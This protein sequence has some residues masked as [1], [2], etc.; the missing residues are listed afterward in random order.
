[1]KLKL[2]YFFFFCILD[3]IVTMN[4]KPEN[5]HTHLM[6]LLLFDGL[7]AHARRVALDGFRA[8]RKRGYDNRRGKK[9]RENRKGI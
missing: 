2:M 1:M 5:P 6:I 3:R 8:E 4:E 9:D 7:C